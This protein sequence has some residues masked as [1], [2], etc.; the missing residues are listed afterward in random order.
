MSTELLE[1]AELQVSGVF[2]VVIA[3]ASRRRLPQCFCPPNEE[4]VPGG[5]SS[6]MKLR[7]SR[8]GIDFSHISHPKLYNRGVSWHTGCRLSEIL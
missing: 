7:D 3:D 1:I 5:R 6:S 4:K 2:S 8:F